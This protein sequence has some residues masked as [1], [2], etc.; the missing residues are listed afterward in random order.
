M[1]QRIR[2]GIA[3]GCLLL[4]NAAFAAIEDHGDY[5]FDTDTGH[6]WVDVTLS[7]GLTW[8]EGKDQMTPT[9][10]FA[11]CRYP[12]LSEVKDL[13][14]NLGLQTQCHPQNS[15]F[16]TVACNNPEGLEDAIRL[17]GD[18]KDARLDETN[19]A[20]DVSPDGAGDTRGLWSS[21]G[22]HLYLRDDEFVDR[23]TGDPVKDY[24]DSIDTNWGFTQGAQNAGLLMIC[25]AWPTSPL[26]SKV[27]NFENVSPG[28][29]APITSR[30]Y[31]VTGDATAAT[32]G[33]N[34]VIETD[35]CPEC[36][37]PND[38]RTSQT[39][40]R[41]DGGPF[42]FFD[43]EDT[44]FGTTRNLGN[45]YWFT[46]G[47]SVDDDDCGIYGT[48]TWGEKVLYDRG[49]AGSYPSSYGEGY[50]A[51][52]G[53]WLNLRTLTVQLRSIPTEDTYR[54]CD[55][56]CMFNIDSIEVNDAAVVEVDFDP[57]NASNII[58]PTLDYFI[59]VQITTT[60]EFT[61]ANVDPASV[62]LGPNNAPLAAAVITG[63]HDGDSDIDYIYG[64]K[65]EQTGINCVHNRIILSGQTIDGTPF[66]ASDEV[67][68]HEDCFETVDMDLEP[69]DTQNRVY[70]ND[71]YPVQLLL[72][73][74]NDGYG[75]PFDFYPRSASDLRMGPNRAK[76]VT[77]VKYTQNK[78]EY[79]YMA[80]F[81]M[82]DT[83]ITCDDTEVEIV[84]IQNSGSYNGAPFP[85]G[86]PAFKATA[87]ISP[88][89]CDTGQCHPD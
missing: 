10:D 24:S 81:R 26:Q 2:F 29:T 84:G 11:G 80:T 83:G 33:G 41:A 6:R 66:A 73:V 20:T 8:Q 14:E 68:M 64:F 5:T 45:C 87:A 50:A 21:G 3:V 79:D 82:E 76:A 57:W 77:W 75:D 78:G 13:L 46:D 27:V 4:G 53:P 31:T 9:G 7:R 65:M 52:T 89:E 47:I 60:S 55:A 88:Q 34:I 12:G 58:N 30:G 67:V 63:N 40:S 18:T 72:K 71:E 62:R 38:Y 15:P 17:L 35:D 70:P 28:A 48:T 1:S 19:N 86:A 22:S 54:D 25:D 36:G 74:M 69:F 61:G 59:T 85:S 23:V 37:G 16:Y 39:I 44:T 51:G 43:I 42:A 32:W 49:Y 56:P